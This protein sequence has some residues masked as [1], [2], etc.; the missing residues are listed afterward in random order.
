V[1]ALGM[2]SA[3]T[4]VQQQPN[5]EAYRLCL[6]A[7]HH[8]GKWN[9][10]DI[11]RSI[12][13]SE[14]A[15]AIDP[16]YARAYVGLAAGYGVL[17]GWGVLDAAEASQKSIAAAEK[18]IELDPSAGDGYHVLACGKAM[19]DYDWEGARKNFERARAAKS[20]SPDVHNDYALL[21][22]APQKRVDEAVKECRR[23]LELDPLSLRVN[24]DLGFAQYLQ[25]DYDAAIAQFRQTVDIDPA[26]GQA[27]MHMFKCFLMKR[28]FPEA[29]QI[30]AARAKS[31]F[32]AEY[33]LHMGRVEALSG[34]LV[35]GKKLL[36]QLQEA[37]TRRCAVESAQIAWLQIAVGDVDGAFQSL[38]KAY[39]ERN[40]SLIN[41]QVGPVFDPIRADPRY[42]ALLVRMHLAPG[43]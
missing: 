41:L 29:R 5:P 23:A 39:G 33:A 14:Q 35:E 9:V 24:S 15:I 27:A 42:N 31:P 19:W 40:S 20:G 32:P 11:K 34:N 22:L 25:R 1:N 37:C 4:A 13:L 28:M 36:H 26:F 2:S 43:T 38:D 7:R 17:R 6:L 18:S 16:H 8:F 10:R 30:V 3:D 21:Y 12:A